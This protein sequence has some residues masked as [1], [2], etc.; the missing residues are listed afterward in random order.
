MKLWLSSSTNIPDEKRNCTW[1]IV[2]KPLFCILEIISWMQRKLL[3]THVASEDIFH[4]LPRLHIQQVTKQFAKK[5]HRFGPRA[6]GSSNFP[7]NR[8][9]YDV[10]TASFLVNNTLAP[11]LASTIFLIVV[12][13]M[14]SLLHESRRILKQTML[15]FVSL[16]CP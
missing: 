16:P 3:Y 9:Q 7:F 6:Y 1:E 14:Q 10:H 15:T 11:T 4:F 13:E 8:H 5:V 2:G 12:M